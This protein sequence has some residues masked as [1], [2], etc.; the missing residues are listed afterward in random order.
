MP[1]EVSSG[2]FPVVGVKWDY[3]ISRRRKTP[4]KTSKTGKEQRKRMF[5]A[6][7]EA[8]TGHKGG[9]GYLEFTTEELSID[10]RYTISDFIDLMEGNFKSFYLFRSDK[11]KF[12]NFY[13]NTIVAQPNIIIPFKTSTITSVTV[14]DASKTFTVTSSIGT[15]GEDRVNFT[16][17]NQSG[18]VRINLTGYQR[19]HVR[20]DMD[21]EEIQTLREGIATTQ[22]NMPIR[23]KEVRS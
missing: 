22:W 19:L 20:F 10:D 4:I 14:N 6:K 5:P 8:G 18:A 7:D 11:D 9:Y 16:A 2:Y 13:V 23:V 15:G 17:G 1:T 12:V 21:D 3:K